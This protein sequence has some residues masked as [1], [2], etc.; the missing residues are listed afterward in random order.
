MSESALLTLL[1][2]SVL[3]RNAVDASACDRYENA[4]ACDR[5]SLRLRP[6]DRALLNACAA[7]RHMKPATYLVALVRAHVRRDAPLPMAE[8]NALK[9]AVSQMSAVGRHLH[10][11]AHADLAGAGR[12]VVRH[13][14]ETVAHAE[15]IR[16]HVAEVV[17]TNLMSWEVEDA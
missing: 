7:A 9:V 8:L 15:D 2:D 12:D 3:E 1:I 6:G 10:Q 5:I 13:L 4:P 11:L 16:R 17:K 14:Q